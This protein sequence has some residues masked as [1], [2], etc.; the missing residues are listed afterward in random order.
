MSSTIPLYVRVIKKEMT[1]LIETPATKILGHWIKN[2]WRTIRDKKRTY[3]FWI[4]I[5]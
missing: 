5:R 4:F 3:F 2:T 1:K